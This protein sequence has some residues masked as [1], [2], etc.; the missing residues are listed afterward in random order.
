MYTVV[1]RLSEILKERNMTQ[2]QLAQVTGIPQGTISKFDKNKQHMDTHLVVIS[3]SLNL[4]IEEL[5]H[6]TTNENMNEFG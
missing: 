3:R 6:I 2:V 4:S 1:P 5:F